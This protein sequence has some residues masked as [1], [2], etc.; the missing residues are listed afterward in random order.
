MPQ[1]SEFEAVLNLYIEID[2]IEFTVVLWQGGAG[3]DD[4]VQGDEWNS[5]AGAGGILLS[6]VHQRRIPN[7]WRHYDL[8]HSR[9]VIS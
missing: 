1:P 6:E 4:E 3:A 7:H 2:W 9:W 5:A 8:P